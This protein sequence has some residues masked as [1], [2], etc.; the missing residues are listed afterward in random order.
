MK[1]FPDSILELFACYAR[2]H[3]FFDFEFR[4]G[5]AR[6]LLRYRGRTMLWSLVLLL[7]FHWDWVCLDGTSGWRDGRDEKRVAQCAV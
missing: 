3:V 5:D 4:F 7:P 1:F 6:V 2:Y